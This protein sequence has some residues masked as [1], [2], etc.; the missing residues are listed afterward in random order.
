MMMLLWLYAGSSQAFGF[1]F[2]SGGL[3]W[4]EI[5][6]EAREMKQPRIDPD[7]SVEILHMEIHI[8]DRTG[9]MRWRHYVSLKIFDE[10]GIESLNEFAQ[11][12]FSSHQ[13]AQ[14]GGRIIRENGRILELGKDVLQDGNH[15]V[16]PS[17]PR[18]FLEEGDIVEFQ[19]ENLA[20][21]VTDTH[22]PLL[23]NV[24]V[25][26]AKVRFQLLDYVTST[27]TVGNY[28]QVR[29][30]SRG[31]SITTLEFHDLPARIMESFSPPVDSIEPCADQ[32]QSSIRMR[33]F[34]DTPVRTT[35]SSC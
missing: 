5:P 31:R 29:R 27:V 17:F 33:A 20:Y 14:V 3:T 12:H 1:F 10:S 35:Y 23:Q 21:T 22:I 19:W 30:R 16:Q 6:P 18:S 15:G 24:P 11:L 7:A 25:H 4:R 26:Y 13:E 8:S 9:S 32:M 28:D 34:R 2:S